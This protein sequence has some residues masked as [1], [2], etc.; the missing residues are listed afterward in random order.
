MATDDAALDEL[1]KEI[2][3]RLVPDIEAD[4]IIPADAVFD[5]QQADEPDESER[6]QPR[7]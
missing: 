7:R 5:A 2:A 1:A 6:K 4:Q 3:G